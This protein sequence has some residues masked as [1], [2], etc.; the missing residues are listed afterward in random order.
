MA[1]KRSAWPPN[2]IGNCNGMPSSPKKLI[3]P[4][5]C[6]IPLHWLLYSASIVEVAGVGI[7]LDDHSRAPPAKN[8][9]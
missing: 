9:I 5:T 1:E 8:S 2:G 6:R 4:S 7:R 3:N